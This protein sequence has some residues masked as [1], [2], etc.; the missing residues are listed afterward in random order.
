MVHPA[1]KPLLDRFQ[2]LKTTWPAR[3]WSWDSRLVCVTS[4]F[5][6]ELESKAR[7]AALEAL[8]L[9]YTAATLARASSDLRRVSERTGGLRMGQLLLTTRDPTPVIAFGL[10]WPWGDGMTTSFRVGIDG[11]DWDDDPYP[12]VRDIFEVQL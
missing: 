6:V 10:W 12:T 3:A 7:A 5:A 9:E 11:L 4:S 2:K 1:W 8:S